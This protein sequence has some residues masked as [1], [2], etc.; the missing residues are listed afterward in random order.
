MGMGKM[1]KSKQ[2]KKKKLAK[3]LAHIAHQLTVPRL[4]SGLYNFPL[5]RRMKFFGAVSTNFSSAAGA[6]AGNPVDIIFRHNGIYQF[7]PSIN[8]PL[9]TR[10]AFTVSPNY[11]AGASYM[12]G[13]DKP[14]GA[15]GIYS[16]YLVHASKI[17]LEVCPI[18][19]AGVV[20]ASPL[21]VVITAQQ[22]DNLAWTDTTSQRCEYPLTNRFVIPQTQTAKVF[23]YR[24]KYTVGQVLGLE[25]EPTTEDIPFTAFSTA[26]PLLTQQQSSWLI[27][28][29]NLDNSV[30]AYNGLLKVKITYFVT[31]FNINTLLTN[32]PT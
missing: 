11:P 14:N 12:L 23:R 1:Y 25:Q 30:A 15:N 10:T 18:T 5:K 6:I 24:K 27:R 17:D 7:G 20:N 3:E 21:E 8:Y 9:G 13:T 22:D 31:L 19:V 32:A 29:S 26:N 28:I 2:G 16:Q 4:Q